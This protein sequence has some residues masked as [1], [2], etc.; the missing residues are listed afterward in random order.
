MI[1]CEGHHAFAFQGNSLLHPSRPSDC[2][3][4][5]RC[6]PR[7]HRGKS[8]V[9]LESSH[10][11]WQAPTVS[12]G[13][14]PDFCKRTRAFP[15]AQGDSSP[16]PRA[17]GFREQTPP[18]PHSST[19]R[20]IKTA[21]SYQGR[22]TSP[23]FKILLF[24]HCPSSPF[25]LLKGTRASR[26]RGFHWRPFPAASVALCKAPL[27]HQDLCYPEPQT[28][29]PRPVGEEHARSQGALGAAPPPHVP[30]APVQGH[31]DFRGPACYTYSPTH[32]Q[33]PTPPPPPPPPCGNSRLPRSRRSH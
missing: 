32:P 33:Q 4:I 13:S 12:G 27:S 17:S 8:R 16:Y 19:T 29:R 11:P 24:N 9:C 25:T 30:T 20:P 26:E 28:R 7:L 21:F 22:R 5:V 3:R 15:V 6:L 10:S 23:R 14:T 1:T 18:P 31:P 2:P